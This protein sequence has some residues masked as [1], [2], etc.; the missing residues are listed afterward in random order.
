MPRL[1]PQNK[2]SLSP[3]QEP[4]SN[5]ELFSFPPRP[6]LHLRLGVH[7]GPQRAHSDLDTKRQCQTTAWCKRISRDFPGGPVVKTPRFQC[8]GRG[9]D[10]WSGN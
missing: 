8:R 9:F 7:T 2:F 6:L 5:T 10:P 1:E 3:S 4:L